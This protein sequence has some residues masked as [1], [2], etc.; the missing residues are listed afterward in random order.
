MLQIK[1]LKI[2]LDQYLGENLLS[3]MHILR[4]KNRLTTIKPYIKSQEIRGNFL[5]IQWLG[6]GIFMTVA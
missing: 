5:A 1:S 4:R 6:L 3:L 2:G